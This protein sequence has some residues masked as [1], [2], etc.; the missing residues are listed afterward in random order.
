MPKVSFV[1]QKLIGM[2]KT[3]SAYTPQSMYDEHAILTTHHARVIMLARCTLLWGVNSPKSIYT[4]VV[5][6]Q[7]I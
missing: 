4:G 7:Q 1:C 3:G 2:Y 5:T 6:E